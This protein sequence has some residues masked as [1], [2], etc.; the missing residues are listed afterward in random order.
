MA[1]EALD[2]LRKKIDQLDSRLLALLEKRFALSGE[3]GKIKKKNKLPVFE[4][5]REK[6]IMSSVLSK[7]RKHRKFYAAFFNSI[8]SFSRFLQQPPEVCYL[9][10]E[11]TYSHSAALA[12]FGEY[13]KGIPCETIED[14]FDNYVQFGVVPVENSTE[15]SVA[16]TLDYLVEKDAPIVGEVYLKVSHCLLAKQNVKAED[17]KTVYAHPQALAQC[18]HFLKELGV[19]TVQASSNAKACTMLDSRSAAIA[20]EFAAT[21]Y[22]LA[23]L[24]RQIN[25]V[26]DNVTRF[27]VIGTAPAAPT[28]KDK[29]SIVFSL[30]HKPGSL[31]RAL[32]IL[33]EKKLNMTQIESRPSRLMKWEYLFH[34]DFEGHAQDKGVK[35]ALGSLKDCATSL[36]VLGSYPAA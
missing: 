6:Q 1:M 2:S 17:V 36:K 11:G 23:I 31:H 22:S 5:S 13:M 4:P 21:Q 28:G 33:A 25:D 10:P 15:G 3:I 18:K 9:G 29:T 24:K 27:L 26:K 8:I 32:G 35:E 19:E 16:P 14:V 20:S 30:P 12:F 34:I 7:A